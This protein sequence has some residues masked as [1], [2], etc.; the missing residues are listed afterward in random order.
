MIT[1]ELP[2]LEL[3]REDTQEFFTIEG[4]YVSLEHSLASLAAW[5]SKWHKP[6]LGKNEKTWEE[7]IDYVR[8]M[9]ISSD[10]PPIL[11]NGI[12]EPTMQAIASY[13]EDSRTATWF[14]D[15]KKQ[16][17]SREIVT[18]ELIYYWMIALNIPFECQYWHLNRLL[19]LIKVCNIKN[20]PPTKMS[21]KD[22]YARN[23]AL[24]AQ[25][26]KALNTKG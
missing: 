23:R 15:D 8:C 9:T 26:K 1:I 3:F 6:F 18:A 21:K 4:R 19:T 14:S 22:I 25:R 10:V 2:S 20:S 5:E 7:T 16:R 24:N 17:P 12:T 13:I 11:Y